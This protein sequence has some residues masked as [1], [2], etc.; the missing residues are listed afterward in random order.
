M[1]YTNKQVNDKQVEVM[2]NEYIE[3]FIVVYKIENTKDFTRDIN[4]IVEVCEKNKDNR[5]EWIDLFFSCIFAYSTLTEEQL[6][7]LLD[8]EKKNAVELTI[9]NM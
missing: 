8:K 3:N 4:E 2:Y 5:D 7:E 6:N 1:D 9:H